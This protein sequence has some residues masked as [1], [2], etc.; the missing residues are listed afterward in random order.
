MKRIYFLFL[1]LFST[2]GVL[3]QYSLTA[4]TYTQDFNGLGTAT[5]ANVT[6]GSLNNVSATL[7]GWYFMETGTGANTTITAGT[8]SS[9]AGDSYNFGLA[10]NA[11][12]TLGGLRP[13]PSGTFLPYFGF[14]FTNNTGDVITA[15]QISYTGKTWRRGFDNRRDRLDFQYNTTATTLSGTGGVWNNVDALDYSNP[16]SPLPIGS[17]SILHSAVINNFILDITIPDGASFFIRW[18]DLDVVDADDGMGIDDFTLTVVDPT[19]VLFYSKSA[20]NLTALSTWGDDPSGS[21]A[22]PANFTNPFQEFNVVNRASTTLNANWTVSGVRSKVI[23]GDAA[24]ATTLIIPSSAALTGVIDVSD[25]STLR[26][27]NTVLPTLGIIE[28]GST[29]NFAQSGTSVIPAGTYHNLSVTG[30]IK[31]IAAGTTTVTGNMILDGVTGFNGSSG[32]TSISLTGNFTMQNGAAFAATGFRPSLEMA[33]AGTQTLSGGDIRLSLLETVDP[34]ALNIVLNNANLFLS[35]SGL[36]LVESAHRLLLNGNTLS[37]LGSATFGDPVDNLGSIT[38]SNT[39]N[40]TI[41]VTSGPV[42]I[43][44]MTTGAQVLRNLSIRDGNNSQTLELGTPLS[45]TNNLNFIIAGRIITTTANLLTVQQG[46]TVTGGGPNQ[47]V[48]GPLARV[49]NAAGDYLFPIGAVGSGEGKF[50][51]VKIETPGNSSTFRAEYFETGAANLNSP[52]CDFNV[53]GTYGIG[54]LKI[55]EHYN[56]SRTGGTSAAR[57]TFDFDGDLNDAEWNTTAPGTT[58]GVVMAHYNTTFSCWEIASSQVLIYPPIGNIT[59]DL[60]TSFSPF[61]FGK[62]AFGNLPVKFG[63]VKAIEQSIDGQT[64]RP[65]TTVNP[66]LNNGGR[67]DYSYFD[68]APFNGVNFYRIQSMEIDGKKLYSVIVRVD[69]KNDNIKVTIYP[70]PVTDGQLLLQTPDL[71]RGVYSVNIFN[72]MGQQVHKVSINHSGG[73][74]TQSII[75]PT[76]LKTGMYNLQLIGDNVR[77]TKI[78]IIQ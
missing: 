45:I 56:I 12:R 27:E 50:I 17:G 18:S 58:E 23:T 75:L 31:T 30:G 40:I 36:R 11:D 53:T 76:S 44:Q 77:L 10:A 19:P 37:M 28:E 48:E 69:T 35:G 55:D 62:I 51:V 70:N 65:L 78:F 61:V 73:F 13:N 8:G 39:S 63:N 52:G 7:N 41:D 21:G 26:L 33:G 3:G 59:T 42:G 5:S 6:G 47:Y 20:G 14:Y 54:Q 46:A 9:N 2:L 72:A 67:A 32:G 57:I 49:T 24:A 64:F 1:S 68:A 22:A 74:V 29:V 38:G 16:V 34:S 4:S 15:L 66:T 60:L 25:L 71:K 43:L